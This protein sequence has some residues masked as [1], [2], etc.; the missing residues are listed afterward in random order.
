MAVPAPPTDTAPTSRSS[1]RRTVII[2]VAAIWLVA[3]AAVLILAPRAEDDQAAM[4]QVP[5]TTLPPGAPVEPLVVSALPDGYVAAGV[6]RL[7][8][9]EVL[10]R[11]EGADGTIVVTAKRAGFA[12]QATLDADPDAVALDV[13]DAVGV[14]THPFN[15]E[16]GRADSVLRW[17]LGADLLV[18][19]RGTGAAGDD[20][21]ELVAEGITVP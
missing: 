20:E 19:V 4:G 8:D 16:T 18:M 13:G 3:S 15:A 2:A 12:A 17:R 9:T 1:R 5:E 21:V 14:L 7:S 11:F 6:E 10:Q